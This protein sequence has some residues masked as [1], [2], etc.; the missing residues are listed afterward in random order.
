MLIAS[1]I[2]Q[3][4]ELNSLIPN[5]EMLFY[6]MFCSPLLTKDKRKNT[7]SKDVLIGNIFAEKEVSLTYF[8][9]KSLLE[10]LMLAPKKK[11]FKKVVAHFIKYEHKNNLDPRILKMI[12]KI[13]IE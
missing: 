13:G 2:N 4:Y 9:Y 12:I 5:I 6:K 8:G 1:M 10:T 11:H 7:E 3:A